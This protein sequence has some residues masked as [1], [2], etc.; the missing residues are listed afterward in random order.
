MAVACSQARMIRHIYIP[1]A[2]GQ[3]HW[4]LL[5]CHSVYSFEGLCFFF[6]SAKLDL[7]AEQFAIFMAELLEL[8]FSVFRTAVFG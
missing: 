1:F 6:L 5:V 3:E 7:R 8:V 4:A 2:S